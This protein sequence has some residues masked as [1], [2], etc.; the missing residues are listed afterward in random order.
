MM[1]YRRRPLVWCAIS[2]APTT[3]GW[4]AF[5]LRQP[6]RNEKRPR[7]GPVARSET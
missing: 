2:L 5:S 1:W 6:R 4:R 7:S 3:R